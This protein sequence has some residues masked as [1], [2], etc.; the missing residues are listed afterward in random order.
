[1]TIIVERKPYLEA[2]ERES[3]RS[4][5]GGRSRSDGT[6]TK[7]M[8]H[9]SGA[10]CTLYLG[11]YALPSGTNRGDGHEV[12]YLN[13]GE[14]PDGPIYWLCDVV[15]FLDALDEPRCGYISNTLRGVSNASAE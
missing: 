1:M 11:P 2:I 7:E 8:V 13:P 6:S 12:L 14:Q 3:G 5:R 15:R 4:L 9:T 10:R